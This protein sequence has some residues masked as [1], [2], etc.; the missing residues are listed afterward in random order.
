M[1]AEISLDTAAGPMVAVV[2]IPEQTTITPKDKKEA[3][4]LMPEKEEVAGFTCHAFAKSRKGF[5]IA[6]GNELL[7]T[8]KHLTAY[9][10]AHPEWEN[11]V[12]TEALRQEREQKLAIAKLIE[13]PDKQ[14]KAIMDAHDE[15]GGN[16]EWQLMTVAVPDFMFHLTALAYLCVGTAAEISRL[17]GKSK[18]YFAEQVTA[19]GD[20]LNDDQWDKLTIRAF[21]ELV[22]SNIG[23]DYKILEEKRGTPGAPANPN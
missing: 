13:D 15:F 14:A 10:A 8:E 9:K 1:E 5:V 17:I 11:E 22:E 23:N 20:S 12:S 6:T 19:W 21:Q 3:A 7:N 2:E 4:F 18:E 16:L